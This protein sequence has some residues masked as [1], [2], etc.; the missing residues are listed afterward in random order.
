[1]AGLVLPFPRRMSPEER[2]WKPRAAPWEIVAG[3]VDVFEKNAKTRRVPCSHSSSPR[4]HISGCENFVEFFAP[5]RVE[6]V[7]LKGQTIA[8]EDGA[9]ADSAWL[10]EEG[11][12]ERCEMEEPEKMCGG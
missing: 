10:C 1:M 3:E 8:P 9:L 5:R 2:L 6:V 4:H 7:P 12:E 11:R